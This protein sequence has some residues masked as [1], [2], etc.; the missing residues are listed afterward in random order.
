MHAL[1][2]IGT[3]PNF[4]KVTQFRKRVEAAGLGSLTLVHTG[5]HYDRKMSEVFFEQFA[6]RPD[7]VLKLKGRSAAEQFANMVL[8]LVELMERI[9]PDFVLVP[10]DVNSTLAGALAAHRLNLP[11][12]HL[13]AGLRSF[14]RTMP[15]E[16]NR[17]LVDQ[18]S[19]HHFVTEASGA[20]HLKAEGL[21]ALQPD[22]SMHFVGNTMIDTLVAFE[23][24][25]QRST[26]LNDLRLSE[27]APFFL[28]T[29][30]RPATVDHE[31]GLAFII[32]LLDGLVQRMPVVFPIHPR[33]RSNFERF[34]WA[35]RLQHPNV[36]LTEPLDYFAF[37]KLVARAHSI[38]TDSG[39]IQ[40]ES[41]F[42][43]VP[44]VT[45]RPNTERPSTVDIGTNQ[46]VPDFNVARVFS[47]L[48][49]PKSGS[50]PPLWDGRATDRVV[51][52]LQRLA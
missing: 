36:F 29:M 28:L 50:V 19:S 44:C 37:Q 20:A 42:R 15:E 35:D 3:R 12:G 21:D 6:L 10:G 49:A 48:D 8:Q 24:Q 16:I 14:D 9:K 52:V 23:D 17:L 11:V 5:Q 18:L 39:G 41:T 32:D 31:Q 46:L 33:T 7:Y 30:H 26:I 43:R 40:E 2:V 51:E 34:G 25:I 38:V 1:I 47:A 4:I 22:G 13:E 27:N 45:L